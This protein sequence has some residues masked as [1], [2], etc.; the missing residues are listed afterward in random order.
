MVMKQ[1][2]IY[3]VSLDP[4]QGSE[5]KKK[6]PAVIIS[7]NVMNKHLN[8][9]IIAP[10]THSLKRYPSR[11]ESLFRGEAGEIVLDQLRA[12]DKTR[13]KRK[14]G[15]VSKKNAEEIK[16]VMRTMFS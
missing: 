4:A 10:L 11:V 16:A 2:D 3:E 7:P 1:F 12:V 6:R 9:V 13:L 5:M 8:T 15:R 14:L